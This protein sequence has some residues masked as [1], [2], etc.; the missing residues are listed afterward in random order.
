MRSTLQAPHPY[1]IPAR[2]FFPSK[3]ATHRDGGISF[4]NAIYGD[5][6]QGCRAH[7]NTKNNQSNVLDKINDLIFFIGVNASHWR[8]LM[9]EKFQHFSASNRNQTQ[10]PADFRPGWLKF[11][12]FTSDMRLHSQTCCLTE[13]NLVFYGKLIIRILI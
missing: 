1:I 4:I 9:P 13:T 2:G 10:S 5:I 7:S 3:R 8:F 12:R 6:L 11:D